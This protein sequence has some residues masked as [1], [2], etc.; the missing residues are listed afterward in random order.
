MDNKKLP[1]ILPAL[2]LNFKSGERVDPRV[3]V[4]RPTPANYYG[5]EGQVLIADANLPRIEYNPFTGECLGLLVEG[6]VKNKFLNSEI[7]QT[8]AVSLL[9][10]YYH[11]ITWEGS[12]DISIAPTSGTSYSGVLF[13]GRKI[14]VFK[15]STASTV[16]T[17][18]GDVRKVMLED[19]PAGS[20]YLATADSAVISPKELVCIDVKDLL[21]ERTNFT[22]VVQLSCTT[23]PRGRHNRT[24]V[25]L[26]QDNSSNTYSQL[27]ADRT[28]GPDGNSSPAHFCYVAQAGGDPIYSTG[29]GIDLNVSQVTRHRLAFT[30]SYDGPF[31]QAACNGV[32]FGSIREAQISSFI[33]FS[34]LFIGSNMFGTDSGLAGHIEEVSFYNSA[35]TAGELRA[36][37]AVS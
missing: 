14:K 27:Y 25:Q 34:K 9:T 17:V 6:L 29:Y 24:Y 35:L 32:T 1:Q 22:Y 5:K 37:T 36:I 16:F 10:G 33:G 4:E 2:T 13:D 3:I 12:G 19:K 7:G 11:S 31:A 8:Q 20:R 23:P 21:A 18:T 30:F 28:S 15:P 26:R